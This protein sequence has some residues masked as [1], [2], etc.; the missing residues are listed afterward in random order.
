METTGKTTYIGT[1]LI[2]IVFTIFLLT[3]AIIVR[4]TDWAAAHP[5]SFILE[6]LFLSVLTSLPVFVIVYTRN[7]PKKTVAIDF[8]LVF[9]Q[10]LIFWLLSEFSGL[11]SYVFRKR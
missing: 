7:F 9:I 4:H 6:T 1:I 5:V 10:F 2:G 11:T 8:I 3:M